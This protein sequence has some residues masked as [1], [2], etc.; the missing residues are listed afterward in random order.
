[1]CVGQGA[2]QGSVLSPLLANI[3]LHQ[4]DLLLTAQALAVVRY[5]DDLVVCCR[6]KSDA[7]HALVAV[8]D[9]LR[10]WGLQL[11]QHKTQVVHFSQGFPWLGYFFVRDECYQ[12]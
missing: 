1:M 8:H 12:L 3:Y 7:Q 9:A 11:N 10:Q 6:R 4:V 2:S 5:A